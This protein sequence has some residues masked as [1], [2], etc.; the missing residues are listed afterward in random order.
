MQCQTKRILND[1]VLSLD[2]YE[3][4]DGSRLTLDSKIHSLKW[5]MLTPDSGQILITA[6]SELTETEWKTLTE[7]INNQNVG[8]IG[9][10]FCQQSFCPQDKEQGRFISV[11]FPTIRIS[12]LA[13]FMLLNHKVFRMLLIH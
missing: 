4:T 9:D 8:G 6:N 10:Q 11:F 2:Y 7:W 3:R 12:S 13:L 1:F 5:E